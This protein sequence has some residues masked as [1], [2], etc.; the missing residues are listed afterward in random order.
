MTVV[1]YAIFMIKECATDVVRD[2]CQSCFAMLLVVLFAVNFSKVATLQDMIARYQVR[3]SAVNP[4]NDKRGQ[5]RNFSWTACEQRTSEAF[6]LY[7][8]HVLRNCGLNNRIFNW[9]IIITS[10][11][12]I[13]SSQVL[14]MDG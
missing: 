9:L 7:E 2:E 5:K 14:A 11:D 8:M 12:F 4:P 3:G 10:I 13:F 6:S 1:F